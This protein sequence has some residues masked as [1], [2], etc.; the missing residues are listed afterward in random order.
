MLKTSGRRE[1][2]LSEYLKLENKV[3]NDV[4]ATWFQ[5]EVKRRGL[6]ERFVTVFDVAGWAMMPEILQSYRVGMDAYDPSVRLMKKIWKFGDMNMMHPRNLS[7][8][9]RN[10]S[11]ALFYRREAIDQTKGNNSGED[12]TSK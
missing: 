12:K 8:R 9:E 3:P 10:C 1:Q 11:S 7:A 4:V 6:E 5:S 2:L